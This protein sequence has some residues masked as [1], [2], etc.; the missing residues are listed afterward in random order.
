M[1]HNRGWVIIVDESLTISL[2]NCGWVIK[3]DYQLNMLTLKRKCSGCRRLPPLKGNGWII[4]ARKWRRLHSRNFGQCTIHKDEFVGLLLCIKCHGCE[5]E[6]DVSWYF[7]VAVSFGLAST[8]RARAG[9]RSLT[10]WPDDVTKTG[11]LQLQVGKW[12]KKIQ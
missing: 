5:N 6:D 7:F 3:V 9:R 11:Q 10:K 4:R 12:H 2:E 8:V 1:S